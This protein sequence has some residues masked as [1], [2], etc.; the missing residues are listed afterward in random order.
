LLALQEIRPAGRSRIDAALRRL[1]E[2]GGGAYF[3]ETDA[4]QLPQRIGGRHARR[5]TRQES[6]LVE[7]GP[8]FL[9]ALLAPLVLE[10]IFR[11]KMSLFQTTVHKNPDARVEGRGNHVPPLDTRHSTLSRGEFRTG[12]G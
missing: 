3:R 12:R 6:P 8:W 11:R 9:L 7:A 5:V 4:A 10:W 2:Q 1:A